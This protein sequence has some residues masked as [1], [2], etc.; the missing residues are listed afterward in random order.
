MRLS[1]EGSIFPIGGQ[2]PQCQGLEDEAGN[3]VGGIPVQ[4]YQEVTLVPHLVLS[5]F[6]QLGCPIDAGI[7]GA[8]SYTVPLRSSAW[9]VFGAG[10]YAAPARVPLYG[11]LG[12][13][14]DPRVI[15]PPIA[16]SLRADVVWA[17]PNGRTF[18]LG[19][20]TRGRVRQ[21]VSFGSTF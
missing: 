4:R 21:M 9:F 7:G 5:G 19:V 14:L 8:L 18:N 20:E 15:D 17:A 6:S 13:A 16:R 2:F 1:L 11:S 12:N 3:S 10:A